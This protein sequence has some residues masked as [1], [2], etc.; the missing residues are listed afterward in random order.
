MPEIREAYKEHFQSPLQIKEARTTEERDEELS[1]AT[2]F[3]EIVAMEEQSDR[4]TIGTD[5]VK[6]AIRK[7]KSNRAPDRSKWKA[8]WIKKGGKEM[9]KSLSKL[10][11]RIEEERQVPRQWDQI[12]IRSLYKKGPKEDLGNQRGIF[13]TN[14]I[15]KIYE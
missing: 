14:I 12:L 10:F 6:K 5:I 8:E 11:N 3:Q 4:L 1:A 7:T 13:L 2:R 15:S 9:E